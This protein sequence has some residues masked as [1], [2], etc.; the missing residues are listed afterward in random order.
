MIGLGR[1]LPRG[2]ARRW[3]R[4]ETPETII[5]TSALFDLDF[6]REQ[7]SEGSLRK[8]DAA[9]ICQALATEAALFEVV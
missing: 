7:L 3:R 4:L 6:V 1:R 5:R 8:A 9:T 2:L